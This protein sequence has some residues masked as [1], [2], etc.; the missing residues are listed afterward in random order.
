M[1]PHNPRAGGCLLMIAIM[2][3]FLVGLSTGDAMR[4]VILGTGV[5]IVIA[6]A[7]W[8]MDKRRAG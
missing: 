6:V 4:G 5:G 1:E 7:V 2:L 3:G 8:L